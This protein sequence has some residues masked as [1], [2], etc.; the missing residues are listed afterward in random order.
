MLTKPRLTAITIASTCDESYSGQM[1]PNCAPIEFHDRA[2]T[3]LEP[4]YIQFAFSSS[5][6]DVDNLYQSRSDMW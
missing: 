2:F 1:L 4:C 6:Y 3:V 5:D